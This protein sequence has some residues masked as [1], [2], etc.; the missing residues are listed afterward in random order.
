MGR[1]LIWFDISGGDGGLSF[2]FRCK[3]NTGRKKTGHHRRHVWRTAWIFWRNRTKTFPWLHR[4]SK[5][6]IS[7]RFVKFGQPS[8]H[9]L[10]LAIILLPVEYYSVS[11]HCISNNRE[12]HVTGHREN[13]PGIHNPSGNQPYPPALPY[14]RTKPPFPALY[15]WLPLIPTI[16]L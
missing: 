3:V 6:Q 12:K 8:F 7:R 14:C 1:L 4:H 2:R 5:R 10:F 15:Y 16:Q 11:L 13:S 9:Q